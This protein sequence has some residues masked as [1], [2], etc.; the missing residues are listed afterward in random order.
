MDT[1]AQFAKRIGVSVK[2]IQKWDRLAK[3]QAKCTIPNGRYDTDDDLA[4]ALDLPG[5]HKDRRTVTYCPVSSQAQI[6]DL[7]NQKEYLSSIV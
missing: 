1:P 7:E 4:A 3:L 5:L 6:P 2:L